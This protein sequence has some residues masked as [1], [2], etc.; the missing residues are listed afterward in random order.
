MYAVAKSNP[1]ATVTRFAGAASACSGGAPLVDPFAPG[2]DAAGV[3]G[4]AVS[5]ANAGTATSPHS[6]HTVHEIFFTVPPPCLLVSRRSTIAR[7]ARGITARRCRVQQGRRG[8]VEPGRP[9]YLG[10]AAWTVHQPDSQWGGT[11]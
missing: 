9:C 11:P 6:S 3:A 2:A 5:C 1:V 4:F 8:R 10:P 7:H